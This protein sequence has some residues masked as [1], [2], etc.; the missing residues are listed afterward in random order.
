M[1]GILEEADSLRDSIQAELTVLKKAIGELSSE[2]EAP[3]QLK[4]L[5]LLPLNGAR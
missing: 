2:G 1:E 4:V 3:S 5:E